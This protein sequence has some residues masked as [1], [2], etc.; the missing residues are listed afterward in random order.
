V[1]KSKT[2]DQRLAGNRANREAIVLAKLERL[3]ERDPARFA[4]AITI[5]AELLAR[6]CRKK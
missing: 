1:K 6:S 2:P 5:L 3:E 4:E